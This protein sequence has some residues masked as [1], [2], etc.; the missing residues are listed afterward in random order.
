MFYMCL[1][2]CWHASQR[3]GLPVDWTERQRRTEWVPLDRRQPSGKLCFIHW[4]HKNDENFK[5]YLGVLQHLF[6]CH[7]TLTG[8]TAC[9][10]QG[11]VVSCPNPILI[12][13]SGFWELEA[14]P[15]RQ[16]LQLKG[17]LCG[18]DLARGREVERRSLQLPP[19]LHLQE[20]TRWVRHTVL[21]RHVTWR[22]PVLTANV[23]A[24]STLQSH[25]KHPQ[26][27]STPGH[28]ALTAE[29]VI[30]WTP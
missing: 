30:Q 1:S 20:R 13:P 25:V 29:T 5:F 3:P 14:E 16:L 15:A 24:L 27:W 17:G 9:V 23:T 2:W 8:I 6:H 19:A 12:R 26:R 18:H 10:Q 7:P 11:R 28:W 21:L 4:L 22:R